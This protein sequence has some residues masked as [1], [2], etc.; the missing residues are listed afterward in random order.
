MN[1]KYTLKKIDIIEMENNVI[2]IRQFGRI[3]LFELESEEYKKEFLK[4][5]PLFDGNTDMESIKKRIALPAEEAQKIIDNFIQ[6]QLIE[7]SDREISKTIPGDYLKFYENAFTVFDTSVFKTRDTCIE[8]IYNTG[9]TVIGTN[10]L[11]LEIV[12]ILMQFG[13]VRINV[14]ALP[15]QAPFE[16]NDFHIPYGGVNIEQIPIDRLSE[17]KTGQLNQ[18][19]IVPALRY[20]REFFSSINE[21]CVKNNIKWMPMYCEEDRAF[22]GP[23]IVP[24]K[25]ACF[26]C[27]D[28]R[29]ISNI[30]NKNAYNAYIDFLAKKRK[31][32]TQIV[33]NY[34]LTAI[35]FIYDFIK[36]I[37]GYKY[38]RTFNNVMCVSFYDNEISFN[39]LLKFPKCPVCSNVGRKNTYDNYS[40]ITLLSALSED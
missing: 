40:Y 31:E 14:I 34:R 5:L 22:I 9:V 25:T 32:Y 21:V 20:D 3:Y 17:L 18:F 30:E 38:A 19:V 27:M 39:S 33:S 11:S 36:V 2:Q 7:K 8:S 37:T 26:K 12:N 10:N 23:A 29:L 15:D 35:N 6:F 13:F 24:R 28:L 16:R 4:C 1:E